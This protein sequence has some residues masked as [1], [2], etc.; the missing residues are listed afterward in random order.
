MAHI[1]Y[2]SAYFGAIWDVL[3]RTEINRT[4]GTGT[5]TELV[6]RPDAE[7]G[8]SV[9]LSG[10]GFTY[11]TEGALTGGTITRVLIVD[12][13]FGP[14]GAEVEI[15]DIA[16]TVAE[17]LS[18]QEESRGSRFTELAALLGPDLSID[19]SG[20]SSF[21]METY[22]ASF[23]PDLAA[24]ATGG[25]TL[26]GSPGN[27][28]AFGATGNDS[29]SGGTGNDQLH[30]G[31]G[32]DT[33]DGGAGD[34]FITSNAYRALQGSLIF[35]GDGD[36]RI[37]SHLGQTGS[38]TIDGGA[39]YDVVTILGQTASPSH[40][41]LP[42]MFEQ[43]DDLIVLSI[44]EEEVHL[45][46][47]E[48][49]QISHWFMPNTVLLTSQIVFGVMSLAETGTEGNDTMTGGA[50]ND[51]LL[52]AGGD[53]L[54]LGNDGQDLLIAGPGADTLDGGAGNDLLRADLHTGNS[55]LLGGA[56]N[57]T[58]LGSDS[59]DTLR[60]GEGDDDLRAG[61]GYNK[62]HGEDGNDTINGGA[63]RDEVTGG[64]G[65]DI[66]FLGDGNDLAYGQDGNDTINGGNGVD[67]IVGQAGD[68]VIT[69]NA[70]SDLLFGGEGNDFLNGG[71]GH[72]RVNGGSGAD[73]FF[74]EG[75]AGHGSDWV[76]D[77]SAAEG[78]I[79]QFGTT[80]ATRSQFQVNFAHTE[81]AAGERAGDDDV[82]E[83][84]VIYRPTGQIIWALVD[85]EGQSEIN[86][87]IGADVFD[88][89]A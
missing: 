27:D 79:L 88:L 30:G 12:T 58:L 51:S 87:Q 83:A 4:S 55:L 47:V 44:G 49:V 76:Q 26:I 81:N 2:N 56:G 84:F 67:M 7:S 62:L 64:T 69:G 77:Y 43:M 23:W 53:D 29:L 59:G 24:A 74:H 60:G 65:D 1:L 42:Y 6:A 25:L 16:W 40:L 31:N 35:G 71:F 3:N 39:G 8:E 73:R 14:P 33:I 46:D 45:R 9:T 72:D 80:S 37:G 22:G 28:F 32:N 41:S 85:G 19:A 15:T 17:F 38:D 36:D 63:L 34:D 5:A 82:Q 10:T 78:D 54:I 11:D 50:G 70:F 20:S 75:V 57:D 18:A 89:L 66:I 48:Q 13:A 86:L 61:N 52:G 21:I 68:D